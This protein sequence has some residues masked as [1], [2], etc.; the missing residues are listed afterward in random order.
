LSEIGHLQDIINHY[1]YE[2]GIFNNVNT[3]I[4]EKARNLDASF[5]NDD[6]RRAYDFKYVAFP[7]GMSTVS[8]VYNC[9]VNR[10]KGVLTINGNIDYEFFDTYTDPANLRERFIGTS[11]TEGLNDLLRRITD[12]GARSYNITGSWMTRFEAVVF[13]DE[14]QSIHKTKR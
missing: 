12:G 1:A 7:H 4:I 8:G 6:F 3:Q 2:L 9:S 13:E 5:I 10:D 11:E 14:N